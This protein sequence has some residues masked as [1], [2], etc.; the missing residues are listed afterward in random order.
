MQSLQ[1]R[2]LLVCSISLL[3]IVGCGEERGV[4]DSALAEA[5]VE[6]MLAEA[7]HPTDSVAWRRTAEENLKETGYRT[8]EEVQA[9]VHALAETDS[10]GFS[11]LLDTVQARL[12]K[13]R[14]GG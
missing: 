1:G 14:A 5:Y 13:I 10:K 6:V 7:Q 4:F 12:D 9:A 2:L 11:S 8:P 3:F